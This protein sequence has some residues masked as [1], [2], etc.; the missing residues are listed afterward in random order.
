MSFWSK[1][2]GIF[3]KVKKLNSCQITELYLKIHFAF[4]GNENFFFTKSYHWGVRAGRNSIL[5]DLY[6]WFILT[7]F[8]L[9]NEMFMLLIRQFHCQDY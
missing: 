8:G 6:F 3:V 1:S 4:Q 7:S 9:K 5:T 2:Y